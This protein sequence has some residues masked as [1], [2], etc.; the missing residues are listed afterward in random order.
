MLVLRMLLQERGGLH[1]CVPGERALLEYYARSIEH[2]NRG[3]LPYN[4]AH[5]SE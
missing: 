3:P 5:E 2:F 1:A 4:L